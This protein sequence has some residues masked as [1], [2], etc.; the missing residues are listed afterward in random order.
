MSVP[1]R[2][3]SE[4]DCARLGAVVH[5]TEKTILPPM[6]KA[7]PIVLAA[8]FTTFCTANSA[9]AG[10][11]ERPATQKNQ[12]PR[13]PKTEEPKY[14]TRVPGKDGWIWNPYDG[15]VLDASGFA[16]GAQVRDPVSGKVMIVPE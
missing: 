6:K 16:P 1:R 11:D 8:A 3:N 10:A 7:F 15:R 5:L 9:N 2:M 14:A 12:A 4:V 13:A